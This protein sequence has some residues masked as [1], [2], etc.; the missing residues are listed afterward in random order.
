MS[1]TGS[2]IN[3]N[4]TQPNKDFWVN[5]SAFRNNASIYV[6][7]TRADMA[8]FTGN[9][10]VGPGVNNPYNAQVYV[11]GPTLLALQ[12]NLFSNYAVSGSV[13]VGVFAYNTQLVGINNIFVNPLYPYNSGEALVVNVP[14]GQLALMSCNTYANSGPLQ[15]QIAIGGTYDST[16]ERFYNSPVYLTGEKGLG[17]TYVS[18]DSTFF[19]NRAQNAISDS[20]LIST[21]VAMELH[22]DTF[23]APSF[24]GYVFGIQVIGANFSDTNSILN[25][26]SVSITGAATKPTV[27]LNGTQILG[28]NLRVT[29][30]KNLPIGLVTIGPKTKIVSGPGGSRISGAGYV[31]GVSVS[32]KA[33]LIGFTVDSGIPVQVVN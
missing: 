8:L 23:T 13:G 2:T 14:A 5:H 1:T 15:L 24:N 31:Q 7:A 30:S 4:Y 10:L 33:T 16:E 27:T 22:Y 32:R 19:T 9:S 28:G 21:N 6:T 25:N 18:Y 17:G 3:I 26:V 11:S 12:S 29:G 20:L